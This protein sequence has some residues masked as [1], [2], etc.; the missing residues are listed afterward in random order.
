[1]LEVMSLEV[2]TKSVG[3]VTEVQCWRQ[4]VQILGDATE[5]LQVPNAVHANVTVSRLVLEDL[6]KRAS[7][8]VRRL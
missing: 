6:R 1:M 8:E 7:V 2:P 5:K 3:T 4:R